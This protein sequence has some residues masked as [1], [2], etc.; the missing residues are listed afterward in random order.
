MNLPLE[1][2]FS[3]P[4]IVP[5]RLFPFCGSLFYRLNVSQ[6]HK[7]LLAIVFLHMNCSRA[8]FSLLRIVFQQTK[9]FTEHHV[10]SLEDR[11]FFMWNVPG[12]L[13]PYCGS[14]FYAMNCSRRTTNFLLGVAFFYTRV[15]Q[16]RLFP[17]CSSHGANGGRRQNVD[18]RYTHG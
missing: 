3:P 10:F 2:C 13:F 12:R 7:F 1:N 4:R 5:G 8:I 18:K 16:G 9:C 15:V 11:F 6:H 17:F 14:L